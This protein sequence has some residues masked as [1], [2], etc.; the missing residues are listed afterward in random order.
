MDWRKGFSAMYY[1][2]LVDV[3]TWRSIERFEFTGGTIKATGTGL[4][5]SADI[6]CVNFNYGERWVRIYLVAKQGDTSETVPLFTGLTSCPDDDIDGYRI[7]NKVEMY[8]VLKPCEDVLLPRGYYVPV[9][10]DG[11]RVIKK[12]LS[13]TPAPVVIDGEPPVLSSYIVAEDGETHLSM[14]DK[15]LSAINWRYR[16]DGDGTIHIQPYSSEP[17]AS[18]DPI[19]N[20]CLETEIKKT[21]DWYQ[22]PNVFRAVEDEISAVARDDNPDS[23]FSTVTRGREIWMEETSCKLNANESLAQYAVRRLNEEQSVS[24]TASY[25]RRFNPDVKVTDV[26]SLNYP[27]QGLT[28][29]FVVKSYSIELGYGAR[30]S[31]EVIKV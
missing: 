20:D 5:E 8:S 24:M 27:A 2:S 4:R 22:C 18:Y 1:A 14:A 17:V 11:G 19:N 13:V 26:I 10:M 3:N 28:G 30:T 23:A 7:K 15:V 21:Y 12:L 29:N 9:G 25:D 16:I 6:D 31:E